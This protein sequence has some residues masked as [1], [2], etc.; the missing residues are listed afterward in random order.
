MNQQNSRSIIITGGHLTPALAVAA[1]VDFV[2]TSTGFGPSGATVEDV[3]LMWKVVGKGSP[4]S[5][6]VKAAGGVRSLQDATAMIRAG[7]TRLGSSSG[8]KI[9]QQTLASEGDSA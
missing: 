4:Y 5:L 8:L 7:A 9:M 1:G 6:G 2:K 3:G